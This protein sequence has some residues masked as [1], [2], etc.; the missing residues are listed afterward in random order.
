M[1]PFGEFRQAQLPSHRDPDRDELSTDLSQT[2]EETMSSRSWNVVRQASSGPS[3]PSASLC[4]SRGLGGVEPPPRQPVPPGHEGLQPA[5]R[6]GAAPASASGWLWPTASS[7]GSHPHSCEDVASVSEAAAAA[8]HAL[9]DWYPPDSMEFDAVLAQERLE[10]RSA[11]QVSSPLRLQRP[12]GKGTRAQAQPQPFVMSLATFL[13][14][15]VPDFPFSQSTEPAEWLQ[16][17]A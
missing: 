6:H 15:D 11:G 10:R 2:V 3:S 9:V 13:E 8:D 17:Q 1:E 7:E 14:E 12:F 4:G 16:V 5:A